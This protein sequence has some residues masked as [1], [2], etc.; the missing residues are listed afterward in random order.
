MTDHR[1]PIHDHYCRCRN[2]KPALLPGHSRPFASVI[3][4]H[5]PVSPATR[6]AMDRIC[7]ALALAVTVGSLCIM[8]S[9]A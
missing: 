9:A 3:A 8:L 7:M 2:C 6:R 1:D 4:P 5:H